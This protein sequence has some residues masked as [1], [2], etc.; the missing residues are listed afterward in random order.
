MR[1][2]WT[3]LA[4]LA[5]IVVFTSIH[6][7]RW[8]GVGIL[9]WAILAGRD[10]LRLARRALLA[11]LLFNSVVSLGYVVVALWRDEF[12]PGYL[13]LVNARVFLMT[14]STFLMVERVDLF[15][16]LGFSRGLVTVLTLAY[17]QIRVAQRLLEDFRLGLRSRSLDHPS[18]P[19]LY[20]QGAA[21]GTFFLQKAMHD[22]A[23]TAQAM[24]SRGF[25]LDR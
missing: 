19:V 5:A 24:N 1:H 9:T 13:V 4:Y 6:D 17:S 22:A 12:A 10:V 14:A 8:L 3:L 11:I 21:T 16:A 23:D 2:R 18:L 20:R 25:F 7:V 15:R